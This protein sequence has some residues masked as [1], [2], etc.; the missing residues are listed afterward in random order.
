[1]KHNLI[2]ISG[3]IKSGK[4][5][6]GSILQW[7]VTS[8]TGFGNG[9]YSNKECEEW[10][11]G[12]YPGDTSIQKISNY[13]IK[14]YADKLK[15]IVCL[16]IGCTR[17]QLE[18]REFKEQELGE[19]W[20]Y[21]CNSLFFNGKQEMVPYLDADD[22][23]KSNTAWYLIKLTPRKLL[24]LLGT[25]AGRDIIHPQIW[26]NALFADY[27]LEYDKSDFNRIA[28]KEGLID[29]KSSGNLHAL[30]K[31]GITKG[32]I[33]FQLDDK[34]KTKHPNW[35]ITDVRFPNEAKAIKDRGGIVIRVDRPI[36]L[37][38]PKLWKMFISTNPVAA[39]IGYFFSWMLGHDEEMKKLH[40]TL[41]HPSE[42]ALD[43]YEDFDVIINN[44][45][46]ISDLIEKIK[47]LNLV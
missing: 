15:Y 18:Y 23:V 22:S 30:K 21:Y 38:F 47:Q 46:S 24:Q 37:R 43:S 35:I 17:E 9:T 10:L 34:Y 45:G 11:N 33:N 5:T 4:D 44:E 6:V 32:N 31:L 27:K 26:V 3:K 12:K 8:K 28:I 7:I 20:W 14:K 36:D 42:T 1:M 41:H 19:E 25:E 13:L 39:K 40:S 2:G 29:G 16:L